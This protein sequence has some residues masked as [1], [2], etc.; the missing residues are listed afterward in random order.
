MAQSARAE[1][2]VSIKFTT[3]YVH[4]GYSKSN[5]NPSFQG[6]IDYE[7][8][9]GL[10]N[11]AQLSWVDFV[12]SDS[13]DPR[14]EISPYLGWSYGLTDDWR[15]EAILAG[16]LYDSK[17]LDRGA[18]YFESSFAVHY[19]DMVTARFIYAPDSYDHGLELFTYELQTRYPLTDTFTLSAALGFEDG[20]PIREYDHLY[21]NIGASWFVHKNLA[22]DLRY[23][24]SDLLHQTHFYGPA[25]RF[26]P[27][28]INSAVVFSISVGF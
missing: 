20:N 3:N 22:V 16:Y 5:G 7:H 8:S 23:H 19:R 24:D 15:I 4:R 18:D 1:L 21:W 28:W 2:S 12:E 25:I 27:A 17:L 10:F 11:G 14:L 6:N 26:R 9:S 13:S